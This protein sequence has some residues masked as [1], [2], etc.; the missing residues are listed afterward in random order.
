MFKYPAQKTKNLEYKGISMKQRGV[1]GFIKEFDEVNKYM[2][3]ISEIAA[4]F[5]RSV[6]TIHQHLVY[7]EKK[8]FIQR[9]PF[10]KRAIT[11]LKK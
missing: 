2:P 1:L 10:Q 8:G 5:E 9:F 11:I 3:S 6:P 4:Y 7:L